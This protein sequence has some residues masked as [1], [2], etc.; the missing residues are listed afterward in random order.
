MADRDPRGGDATRDSAKSTESSTATADSSSEPGPI[1]R[2]NL[3]STAMG[4]TDQAWSIAY[5]PGF[6]E[7]DKLP[8]AITMH[9]LG[10]TH[11]AAYE[12]LRNQEYLAQAVAGGATPFALAGIDGADTFWTKLRGRDGGALVADEFLGLLGGR[13]LDTDRLALTGWSMGGWGSLFLAGNNLHGKVKAVSAISTPC[14]ETFAQIPEQGW[15]SEQEYDRYNFVTKPELFT[16]LPIQVLCGKQDAF[17]PG[18]VAFAERLSQTPGVLPL[19]TVFVDGNH[20]MPY[21]ESQAAT[22]LA[23]LAKHLLAERAE[24]P[25][26]PADLA[27]RPRGR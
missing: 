2:G 24:C 14:Y 8:V 12:V 9:G 23:F 18:N 17:Y 27:G 20:S 7:G 10:D 4:G 13:G 1:V 19:E 21:W 11:R 25:K 26:T 6:G 15:M 3:R 22:Q 5:P 16:D